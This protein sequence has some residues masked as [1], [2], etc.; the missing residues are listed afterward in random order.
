MM[1]RRGRG[2]GGVGVES[3]AEDGGP[4]RA[5]GC[6]PGGESLRAWGCARACLRC[7]ILCCVV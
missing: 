3:L 2:L 6:G 4:G 1:E 5:E 7:V